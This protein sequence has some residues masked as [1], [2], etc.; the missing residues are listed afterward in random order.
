[1]TFWKACSIT[2]GGRSKMVVLATVDALVAAGME[3]GVMKLV[4]T[5][6]EG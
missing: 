4:V 5:S 3:L 2:G 6:T 1:M